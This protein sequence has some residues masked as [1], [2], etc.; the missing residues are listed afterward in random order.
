MS[1]AETLRGALR[2][3]RTKLAEIA[4]RMKFVLKAGPLELEVSPPE[5]KEPSPSQPK[6]GSSQPA[7][8]SSH[9]TPAPLWLL[10]RWERE[11]GHR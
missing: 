2:W 4:P 8:P 9:S 3:G 5:Q 7:P 1:K 6:P 11:R 10:E